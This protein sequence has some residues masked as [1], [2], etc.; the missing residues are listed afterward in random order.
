[1]IDECGFPR[2]LFLNFVIVGRRQRPGLVVTDLMRDLY[3]VQMAAHFV[4]KRISHG[5]T[6]VI[7]VDSA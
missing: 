7:L 4:M 1:M 6:D 5:G 3:Y 2:L